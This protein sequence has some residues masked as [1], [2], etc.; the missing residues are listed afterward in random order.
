MVSLP[1]TIKLSKG[2]S[3]RMIALGKT[4]APVASSKILGVGGEDGFVVRTTLAKWVGTE[5]FGGEP[6]TSCV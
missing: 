2:V 6:M 5:T 3:S 4:K 1:G